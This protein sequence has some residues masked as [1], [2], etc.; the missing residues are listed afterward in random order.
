MFQVLVRVPMLIRRPRPT[1]ARL[2]VV[3]MS[4]MLIVPVRV[5]CLSAI[6]RVQALGGSY[7]RGQAVGELAD[8]LA[9]HPVSVLSI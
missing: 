5:H 6:V 9:G 4:I 1:H 8:R 3:D 7:R 2:G